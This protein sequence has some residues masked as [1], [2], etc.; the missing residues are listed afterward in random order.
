MADVRTLRWVSAAAQVRLRERADAVL[1]DWAD[2]WGLPAPTGGNVELAK[3]ALSD[4][5]L[6]ARGCLP[7]PVAPLGVQVQVAATL[8]KALPPVMFGC[9]AAESPL[10]AAVGEQAASALFEALST[11]L[12][13]QPMNVAEHTHPIA[14][15]GVHYRAS[16]GEVVVAFFADIRWLAAN[17]WLP[18]PALPPLPIDA[19]ST[20]LASL[21]VELTVEL[22]RA[23]LSLGDLATLAAG[24]VILV[25]QSTTEPLVLCLPEGG[26]ALCAHLGRS[27]DRRAVQLTVSPH[28][29]LSS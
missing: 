15:P 18:M 19:V 5:A 12:G 9:T 13:R 4:E 25:S 11:R 20:A 6:P 26:T 23:E 7:A 27:G 3:A 10:A 28:R 29:P 21:P 16:V 8:A 22:G 2:Q 24:D 17:A 1:S 14:H